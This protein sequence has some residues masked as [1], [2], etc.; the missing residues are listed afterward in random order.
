MNAWPEPGYVDVTIRLVTGGISE[1]GQGEEEGVESY[2]RLALCTRS[3][4]KV[5]GH[6]N[7]SGDER[8]DPNS[9]LVG[10]WWDSAV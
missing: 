5:E 7:K 9:Q 4:A 3:S 10:E 8:S 1:K 2:S 6:G